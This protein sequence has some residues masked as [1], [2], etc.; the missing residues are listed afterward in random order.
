MRL[1]GGLLVLAGMLLMAVNVWRT[2]QM[3]KERPL[4]PVLAPEPSQARA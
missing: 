2:L 3:A 1:G 4:Q